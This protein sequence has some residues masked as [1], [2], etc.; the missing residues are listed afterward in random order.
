[1]ENEV[2]QNAQSVNQE[3]QFSKDIKDKVESAL[4]KILKEDTNLIK[5]LKDENFYIQYGCNALIALTELKDD[6]K[7]L[8][9]KE[10]EKLILILT[11]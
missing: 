5:N 7:G 2:K 3:A 8:E 6:I 4:E 1:M 10:Y 9:D 11:K